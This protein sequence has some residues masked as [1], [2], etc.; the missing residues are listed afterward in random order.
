MEKNNGYRVLKYYL[1][2]DIKVIVIFFKNY[3]NVNVDGFSH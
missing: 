1:F 2:G 3:V